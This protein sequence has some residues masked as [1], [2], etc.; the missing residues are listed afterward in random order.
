[1]NSEIL[2]FKPEFVL[3]LPLFKVYRHG[4][5]SPVMSYPEDT[6]SIKEWNEL[7]AQDYGQLTFVSILATTANAVWRLALDLFILFILYFGEHLYQ[8]N[9]CD[10]SLLC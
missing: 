2:R 6:H 3:P 10:S 1:M 4:D 8:C 5:R 9:F 7:G